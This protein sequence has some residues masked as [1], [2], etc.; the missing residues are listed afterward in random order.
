[1]FRIDA[2]KCNGC[3]ACVA[4]CPQEAIRMIGKSAR[5]DPDLCEECGR[6]VD[7]C[8]SGAVYEVLKQ[9]QLVR[10]KREPQFGTRGKEVDSMLFGRGWLGRGGIGFGRSMGYGRGLGLGRGNPY[11]FCRFYPWLPR[12]WWAHGRGHVPI[13]PSRSYGLASYYG[14]PTPYAWW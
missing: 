13:P 10:S 11:P 1:M 14:Y 2:T 3:G 4:I 12:R 8:A 5:I 7:V 9:P 6:C